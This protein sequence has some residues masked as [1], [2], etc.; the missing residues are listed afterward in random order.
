MLPHVR[1]QACVLDG[2]A[3]VRGQQVSGQVQRVQLQQ[4]FIHGR[5]H[6]IQR[7]DQRPMPVEQH[8]RRRAQACCLVAGANGHP[9]RRQ[10]I[11]HGIRPSAKQGSAYLFVFRRYSNT[12]LGADRILEKS[13]ERRIF[14]L[15]THCHNCV[16]LHRNILRRRP[17]TPIIDLVTWE[18]PH[19]RLMEISP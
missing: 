11:A 3:A 7:I 16:M 6:R 12:R 19:S 8:D 2:L 9:A 4:Q 10:G 14:P 15:L 17:E 5:V 13:L 18:Y 1:D